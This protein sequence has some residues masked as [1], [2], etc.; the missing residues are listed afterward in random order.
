MDLPRTIGWGIANRRLCDG[1]LL[2]GMDVLYK[3]WSNA[4]LFSTIYRNQWVFQFGSQYSYNRW[5][6]RGGYVFAENPLKPAGTGPIG[7]ITIPGG[8][9][10]IDYLQSQFGVI[11]QNRIT[12]GVGVVDVMPGIDFDLFA[13]GMF[14]QSDQ[15]GPATNFNIE[16]YWVGAGLTWRPCHLACERRLS[17]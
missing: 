13:G 14:R 17:K 2:L 6:F 7:G 1:Q 11:N 15:L 5:R 9:P 16:S 8:L 12:G 10:A 4:D 3:D